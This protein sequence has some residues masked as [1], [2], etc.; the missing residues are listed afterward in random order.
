VN[1]FRG[2]NLRDDVQ[3]VAGREEREEGR[4]EQD[5]WRRELPQLRT[6]Q[7][8]LAGPHFTSCHK[9]FSVGMKCKYSKAEIV[10]KDRIRFISR[11][12]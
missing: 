12:E 2:Y 3:E 11:T 6:T 4:G 1:K 8:P 9:S 7:S 5:G 10:C